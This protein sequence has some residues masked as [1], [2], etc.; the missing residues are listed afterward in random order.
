MKLLMLE[1][2]S[3]MSAAVMV[4]EVAVYQVSS[5]PGIVI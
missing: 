5:V 3:R 1:T 4:R 2:S